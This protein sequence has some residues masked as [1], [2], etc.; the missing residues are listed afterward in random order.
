MAAPLPCKRWSWLCAWGASAWHWGHG[1]LTELGSAVCQNESCPFGG[2]AGSA[3]LL[4]G[5]VLSACVAFPPSLPA[6]PAARLWL[7]GTSCRSSTVMAAARSR[8]QHFSLDH[9]TTWRRA[10]FGFG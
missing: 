7:F 9:I 2:T 6:E 3:S 5:P 8:E 4:L 10:L 1:Q